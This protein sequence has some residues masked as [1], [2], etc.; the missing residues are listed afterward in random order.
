MI[1]KSKIKGVV[2]SFLALHEG[3]VI[4]SVRIARRVAERLKLPLQDQRNFDPSVVNKDG[5][6]VLVNGAYAFCKVLQELGDVIKRARRIVWIQQDYSIVPPIPDGDAQS[7]FRRA[8]VER[9]NAGSPDMDFWTTCKNFSDKTP[10]SH[11]VNWNAMAWDPLPEATRH[12][13]RK[14][15]GEDL[16]YYGSYR[17]GRERYFDRYFRME[18]VPVTISSPG[19]GDQPNKKFAQRYPGSRHLPKIEGVLSQELAKHGMGLYVEDQRSHREFHSPANRFYEMLGAGLP[20]VF[21]P[22]AVNMMGR[23]GLDVEPWCAMTGQRVREMMKRREEIGQEQ[24]KA[25]T[26]DFRS[27]LETEIDEAVNKMEDVL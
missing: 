19:L 26:R 10:A 27:D 15:A 9:R 8:F 16:F 20:I 7:P 13:Y 3:S 17:V 25:L 23:A 2:F 22:E 11:Y 21:Q 4:P 1:K 24:R 14:K 18:G 5:V 12:N 6:L